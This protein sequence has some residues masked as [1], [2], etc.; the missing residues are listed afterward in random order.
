[1]TARDLKSNAVPLHLLIGSVYTSP[2]NSAT[3]DLGQYN[4]GAILQVQVAAIAT[5]SCTFKIQHS[6]DD[7]AYTDAGYS[8]TEGIG[9]PNTTRFLFVSPSK[10]K[11][12][13]HI[14]L[15]PGAGTLT[16]GG[17]TALGFRYHN[18]EL[19][20]STFVIDTGV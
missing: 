3:L 13:I 11:R 14:R 16:G 4:G 9:N 18:G 17:I 8:W 10:L 12:Y 15:V 5:A 6:D 1:M 19:P 2:A 20:S 7:S